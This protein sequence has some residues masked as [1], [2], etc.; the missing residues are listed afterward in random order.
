[1]RLDPDG[2]A[3]RSRRPAAGNRPL[4]PWVPYAELIRLPS[5]TDL[6]VGSPSSEREDLKLPILITFDASSST[7][8]TSKASK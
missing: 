7:R 1:M 2:A 5:L 4:R 3:I 6:A 8:R